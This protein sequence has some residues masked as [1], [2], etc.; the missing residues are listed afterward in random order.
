M[1]RDWNNL[2]LLA[3]ILN[4]SKF[5]TACSDVNELYVFFILNNSSWS[6]AQKIPQSL[7][8]GNLDERFNEKSKLIGPNETKNQISKAVVMV[9]EF[10]KWATTHKYSGLEEVWWTSRPGSLS[11][12]IGVDIDSKDNP[13]DVL[14][15]YATG[16]LNGY[17]GISLKSTKGMNEIGFKNPGVGSIDRTLGTSMYEEY[18][19][20]KSELIKEYKLPTVDTKRKLLVR[21][22]GNEELKVL[23]ENAGYELLSKLPN[24]LLENLN[25]MDQKQRYSFLTQNWLNADIDLYPPY[26]RVTGYGNADNAIAKVENPLHNNK[27]SLLMS[28]NIEFE[29][30]GDH[31]VGVKAG[32]KRIMKMRFKFESQSM[33]S[34]LKMNGDPW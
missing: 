11:K 28:K 23:V 1:L 2:K 10:N 25:S 7:F 19:L 17:L 30:V 18:K 16:P 26:V 13:T 31:S 9:K 24:I 6:K 14:T 33:A 15:K 4:K 5:N 27:L 12:A 20:A 29:L 32:G 22:P 34:S 21:E 8:E 3:D